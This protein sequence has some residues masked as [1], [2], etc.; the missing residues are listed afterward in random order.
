M[1]HYIR[2]AQHTLDEILPIIKRCWKKNI[3]ETLIPSGFIVGVSS[4]RLRLFAQSSTGCRIQCCSCGM[5]ATH[6]VVERFSGSKYRSTHLNLYSINDRQE[7]LFTKDHIVPRANGGSNDLNNLQVMCQ[8]CN[9]KKGKMSD[10]EFK[11][12]HNAQK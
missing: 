4:K 8:P 1:G 10:S 6:F 7:V 3:H 2:Q 11:K 5:I 9:N 12:L